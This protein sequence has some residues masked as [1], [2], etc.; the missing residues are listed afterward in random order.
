MFTLYYARLDMEE[1]ETKEDFYSCSYT[2]YHLGTD[3][4]VLHTSSGEGEA[5]SRITIETMTFDGYREKEG[6]SHEKTLPV[7]NVTFTVLYLADGADSTEC[8]YTVRYAAMDG[9]L[10]GEESGSARAGSK[11]GIPVREFD[12]P[13]SN[14]A[15]PR[16]R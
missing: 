10:L 3:G 1:D 16:L 7:G 11:A 12:G 15:P 14:F 2:V 8:R 13:H 5:G 9:T 4:K 6:Q